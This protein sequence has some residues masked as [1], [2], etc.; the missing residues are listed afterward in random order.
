MRN[1]IRTATVWRSTDDAIESGWEDSPRFDK[2]RIAAVDLNSYLN[3]EM[4][5]LVQMASMLD[6]ED[7]A[8]AWQERVEAHTDKMRARLFDRE[9]GVFYDRLVQPDR[10]L[11]LLTPACF[12]PLW[13]WVKVS[14]EVADEMIIR[15]LVNP[16]H[17]FG[18]RPFPTVA[19]SDPSFQPNKGWRGPVWPAVAWMM[20]EILRLHGFQREHDEAVKRVVHIMQEYDVPNE[21]YSSATGQPLGRPA[22][23]PSCA[24]LMDL[25]ERK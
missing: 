16:K 12:T 24:V 13:A 19:Y 21:Y 17:F 23:S 2:G 8:A 4:Q 25:I 10:P 15:Y 6:R 5:V 1:A 18:S 11:R 14:Q 7:E 9:D 3:R 20:I 22:F